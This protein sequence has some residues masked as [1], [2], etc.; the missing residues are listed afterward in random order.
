MLTKCL[1][2]CCAAVYTAV[3]PAVLP[4][5]VSSELMRAAGLA[6]GEDEGYFDRCGYKLKKNAL[7]AHPPTVESTRCPS[8]PPALVWALLIQC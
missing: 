8:P 5:A 7:P 6:L 3:L 2:R 4:L 1:A